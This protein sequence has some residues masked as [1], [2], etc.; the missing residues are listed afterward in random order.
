MNKTSFIRS[1]I[2]QQQYA[3]LPQRLIIAA[4]FK[5]FKGLHS[6]AFLR[7]N[8]AFL[9]ATAWYLQIF[10]YAVFPRVA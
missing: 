6:C 4:M 10:M 2:W 1:L 8:A 7:H 3:M 9:A 5:R